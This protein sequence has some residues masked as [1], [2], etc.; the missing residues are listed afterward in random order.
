MQCRSIKDVLFSMEDTGAGGAGRIRLGD[1]Y[2]LALK[3]KDMQFT[4]TISHLRK[5]GALDESDAANP[6]V[7]ITNYIYGSSNCVSSSKYY[8]VCCINQCEDLLSHIDLEVA[9]PEA[10]VEQITTIV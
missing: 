1:F 3:D 8:D 2:G 6:R 5:L 10:T 9:A 4:E 7:I